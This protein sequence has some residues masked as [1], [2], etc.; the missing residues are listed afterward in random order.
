MQKEDITRI[1]LP[2]NKDYL[3]NALDYFEGILNKIGLDE[4]DVM[5]MRLA[6]E[7]SSLN[8]IEHAFDP[9][10]DGRFDIIFARRPSQLV[11]KVHDKGLPSDFNAALKESG[12]GL[13][14]RLMRGV[15]DEVNFVN[16][17]REGKQVELV[18]YMPYKTHAESLSKEEKDIIDKMDLSQI[19][20]PNINM[21]FMKPEEASAMARC[22]YR[23]Y[24]YSYSLEFIYYPEKIKENIQSGI[25][26][27]VICV[28]ESNEIVG[29][30]A[31]NFEYA[32]AKVGE[33]GQAVVDPRYRG[34]SLF[35][36]MKNFMIDHAKE[37]GMY[38]I[39]SEA[40][41]AH[42]FT[43]KGN[44]ALGAHE[45]GFLICYVPATVNFKKIQKEGAPPLRQSAVLFYL[46]TNEEPKRICYL[47][48]RHKDIIQKIYDRSKLNREIEDIVDVEVTEDIT[49]H[50]LKVSEDANRAFIK[51]L[52]YGTDFES[53]IH[54]RFRDL[55]DKKMELIFIDLPISDPL[56]AHKYEFLEKLGFF[57]VG[58]IP[59]LGEGDV[60]RFEYLNNV[61][62]DPDIIARESQF[63]NELFDYIMSER[64]RVSK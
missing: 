49:R 23:S 5:K 64:D 28:D 37:S 16:L 47:P 1:T 39:Y 18:K 7:E 44:L 48:K 2:A 45:T 27:S 6:I 4:K 8:V 63:V 53:M 10:E 52:K 59:E 21:R 26:K 9:D 31:L 61:I 50:H 32:G 35:T 57:F 58:I 11:L 34:H 30:L 42:P 12:E 51:I 46:K 22:V 25:V 55:C 43:Q 60:V 3:P 17:G 54:F 56:T 33:T 24:G 62:V 15:T 41:T 29:H 38:G 40:V 14:I 36:K 19:E 13:G 20:K